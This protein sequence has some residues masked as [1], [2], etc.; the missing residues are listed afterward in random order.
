M[1]PSIKNFIDFNPR[2]GVDSMHITAYPGMGKSVQGTDIT[3]QCIRN[4]EIGIMPGDRF[5]EWRH[6]DNYEID[7]KVLVPEGA[8]IIPL[9]PVK[10]QEWTVVDY[11]IMDIMDHLE[12]GKLLVVYDR[13]FSR[14]DRARLWTDLMRRISG[15]IKYH[16]IPVVYLDHEAGITFPEKRSG[17]LWMAVEDF[18]TLFVDFR[19]ALIRC[20]FLSQIE[21][22]LHNELRN[23]M[24]WKI[25]RLSMPSK[26][27][28]GKAVRK[29]VR[30]TRRDTY[31]IFFGGIYEP[32]RSNPKIKEKKKIWKMISRDLINYKGGDTDTSTRALNRT[33]S[34]IILMKYEKI[35]SKRGV[36]EDLSIDYST[37][38]RHLKAASEVDS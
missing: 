33:L 31:H 27:S 16:D 24:L 18:V 9:M 8:E 3:I 19:K 2:V 25:Y 35:G 38:D 11:D 15:R 10:F 22:E 5:C 7:I 23:K 28:I 21:A 1:K 20:I 29:F 13:C 6:L 34:K 12:P 4:D 26:N 36:A 32:F 37:V 14:V 17:K 30:R